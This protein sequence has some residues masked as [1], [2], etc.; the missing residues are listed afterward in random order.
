[1]FICILTASLQLPNS[2]STQEFYSSSGN[3]GV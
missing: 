1:M 3:K 2:K